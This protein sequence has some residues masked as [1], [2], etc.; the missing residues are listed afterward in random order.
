[1]YLLST[2]TKLPSSSR[3]PD[4]FWHTPERQLR[5]AEA[6]IH[7]LKIRR[8]P[9]IPT[10]SPRACSQLKQRRGDVIL[11]ILGAQRAGSR[12]MHA[13]CAR[14]ARGRAP[15][16]V[17]GPPGCRTA[18]QRRRRLTVGCRRAVGRE[19]ISAQ[20]T[21]ACG[22]H[23]PSRVRACTGE[24]LGAHSALRGRFSKSLITTRLCSLCRTAQNARVN[25]H[26]T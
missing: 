12:R 11:L 13:C 21:A 15:A 19:H 20:K 25:A 23:C 10:C 9:M 16:A 24:Y 6:K 2:I 7:V 18:P 1:M 3:A 22:F 17:L 5:P 26:L 8:P 14:G 4:L